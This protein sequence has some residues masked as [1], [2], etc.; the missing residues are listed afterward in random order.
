MNIGLIDVDSHNFPNLALMKISA[1]H[2]AKGDAVEWCI[3]LKH[4][5]A[6][7][8]SKVFGDEYTAMDM[9]VIQADKIIYGGTGF[10][11]KVVDGKE[12]YEKTDDPPLPYEMEHIYPDYSLYPD[13]TRNAAF[14][15]L[16]RGCPNNCSY[17]SVSKKEGL[18]SHKVADL[19]EW[20][21]GQKEIVL[22][23]PNILAC[24]QH[25]E[26]LEQLA[27]SGARVDFTQGLDARFI[28]EK[29]LTC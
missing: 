25:L 23:D 18:V 3:P 24:R 8:V 6:V 2:K 22:L 9:T 15:F 16:T 4:Y 26:L 29:T 28:T 1:W 13:L 10:A 21:D 27:A 11:I 19:N 14:G 17:C 20:W 12:V 5:D 7:Y